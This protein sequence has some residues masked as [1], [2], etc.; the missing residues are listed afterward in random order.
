M[1][2]FMSRLWGLYKLHKMGTENDQLSIIILYEMYVGNN[3]K[4]II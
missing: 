4:R 2:D 1:K 3:K